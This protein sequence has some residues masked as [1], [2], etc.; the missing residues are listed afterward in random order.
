[1]GF[2]G[3]GGKEK[4]SIEID[5]DLY[6]E[7]CVKCAQ[8]NVNEVIEKLIKDYLG[9]SSINN[10]DLDNTGNL[11]NIDNANTIEIITKPKREFIVKGQSFTE[12]EFES[13]LRKMVPCNVKRTIF[14]R[15][16]ESEQGIWKVRNFTET[17]SLN[18]NLAAGALRDWR[19][20]G[21]IGIKLEIE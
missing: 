3:I 1:M 18:V 13:Y 19:K 6:T 12:E 21:I 7:F 4:I 14:Y 9:A 10:N 20:L 16:K 5:K 15:N 2:W 8:T 17:S 11:D